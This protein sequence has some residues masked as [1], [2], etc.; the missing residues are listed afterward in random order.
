MSNLGIIAEYNPFHNGHLHHLIQSKKELNNNY[1]ICVMSGN[2]TQ[3]GLPA[4]Y[5][6]WLRTKMALMLGIDLVIELP[7]YYSVNSANYFASYSVRLLHN[8]N[9]IDNLSFGCE[10]NNI[11]DL[12]NIS[13]VLL[14]EPKEYVSELKAQLSNGMTFAKAS[15]LGICNVLGNGYSKILKSPNNILGIEYIK[16]LKKLNSS[17]VPHCIK[18]DVDYLDTNICGNICSATA[19]RNLLSEKK[20]SKKTLSSIIPKSTFEII[21]S[22]TP[23]F[24]DSFSTEILYCIRKMDIDNLANILEVTEGLEKRLKKFSF[25]TDNIYDFIQLVKTKRFTQTKIQRILIHILLDMTKSEFEKIEKN[26][27]SYIRVLGFNSN[28]KKVLKD[29]SKICNIPIITSVKKYVEK[30]GSNP[31]LEKDLLSSNIYC[32][33]YNIDFTQ[34]IIEEN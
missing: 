18:R 4:L 20:Y 27:Y 23:T 28:G 34:K 26:D 13:D 8:L 21:D 11:I 30:Y 24:L 10:C 32:K 12:S 16:S 6:K 9:C 5:N 1:T 19:I 25:E 3:R 33:K 29:I 14:S 31:L 17:I 22:V 7:V 2:F 15:E